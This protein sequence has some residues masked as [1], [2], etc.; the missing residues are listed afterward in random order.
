VAVFSSLRSKLV[1]YILAI[2]FL[3]LVS[4]GAASFLTIRGFLR[5][6][7]AET[8]R[9]KLRLAM[10]NIDQE[11]DRLVQLL[12]FCSLARNVT[13]FVSSSD[14]YP[15]DRKFKALSAFDTI[16]DAAYGNGLDIYIDKLIIGGFAGHS[17]QFG[18]LQGHQSDFAVA[19][20][21]FKAE[22]ASSGV[23]RGASGLEPERYELS[24]GRLGIHLV[25]GINADDKSNRLTGFVV[26]A[27]N[28]EVLGR[29][30]SRYDLESGSHFYIAIGD[31][32]YEIGS[33]R[34]DAPDSSFRLAP[35]G[36]AVVDARIASVALAGTQ[37]IELKDGGRK[38]E[39]VLY[40]GRDTGWVLA[41]SLPPIRLSG[42]TRSLIPLFFIV[43]GS[44]LILVGLVLATVNRTVNK[45]IDRINRRVAIVAKGDFSHDPDIEWNNELGNIGRAV[46]N[47]S[48]DMETLI[49]RRVEDEK[50]KKELEFRALQNQINPHFLYNTLGAIKWM[51]E[52]QK[53]PGI[54]EMVNALASLLRHAAQGTDRLVSLE[55]ELQL[56]REYCTIQRYRL[57]NLFELEVDIE[58]PL[59]LGSRIV[60]FTL[61]PIVENAIMHGI[62]P[63]MEPGRIR[64][65]GQRLKP[66]TVR[67][68][69]EDDG[70]G[71][72]ASR[73]PDILHDSGDSGSGDSFNRIGLANV[74]SRLKLAFGEEYGLSVE[75]EEGAYTRVSILLPYLAQGERCT[76]S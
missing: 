69:V 39:L 17:I 14:L 34:V 66:D 47:L 40:R 38:E 58:D 10:D 20:E 57:A 56:V 30:L 19:L 37:S 44:I 21:E 23:F 22:G 41:Q 55:L 33:S 6:N 43:T 7:Q 35:A 31:A 74:D 52:I 4:L 27:V 62:E 67:I 45:P 1:G 72:A 68:E 3:V 5:D 2:T 54:G 36:K 18:I 32:T 59:L 42:Q 24:G 75:S 48:R 61:Q 73:L 29:F 25:K 76:P 70:V 11:M 46:N 9:Y 15:E 8:T 50:A 13:V 28:Q 60:R 53:S 49:E 71:I 64:I 16:H 12:N 65:S 63:K 51:A 26:M